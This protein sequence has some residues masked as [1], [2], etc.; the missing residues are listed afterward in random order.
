MEDN[1]LE[2]LE[3]FE[4]PVYKQGSMSNNEF[5]PETFI[6]FW[7]S[8]SPDHSH[9]DNVRYGTAWNYTV[10]VFSSDPAKVP[11]IL[12]E[13]ETALIEAGWI[14][15]GRGY[16]TTSDQPSHTGRGLDI[17]YLEV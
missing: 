3:A 5:Y 13:L 15:Q 14:P 16:D 9:Y 2:I 10:N 4:V 6:T 11:Q 12:S 7:N 1:L 8:D 17:K